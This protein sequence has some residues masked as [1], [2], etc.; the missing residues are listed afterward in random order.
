MGPELL[1]GLGLAFILLPFGLYAILNELGT[2][3]N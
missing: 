2:P 1:L 3:P